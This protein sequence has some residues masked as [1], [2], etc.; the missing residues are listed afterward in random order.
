M[1]GT[2]LNW[3]KSSPENQ[4]KQATIKD[5]VHLKEARKKVPEVNIIGGEQ[6]Q[7]KQIYNN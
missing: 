4:H 6:V 3:L 7:Q 5:L 2:R 1:V